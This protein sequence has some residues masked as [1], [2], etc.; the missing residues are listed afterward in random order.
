MA[1]ETVRKRVAD[2]ERQLVGLVEASRKLMQ[3]P[4][5]PGLPKCAAPGGTHDH[6][7]V[8]YWLWDDR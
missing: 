4:P 6:R 2:V 7:K 3:L 8:F 5:T 1:D